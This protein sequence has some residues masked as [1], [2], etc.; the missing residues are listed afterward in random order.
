MDRQRKI[1][2]GKLAVNIALAFVAM[3]GTLLATVQE[4][5]A[6]PSWS[7]KY[8]ADCSACHYPVV[9]RLNSFGQQFRRAGYR[10]PDEIGKEQDVSKV[11]DFMSMRTRV[12]AGYDD[13][14]GK[15]ARTETTVSDATLFYAGSISKHF[16]AFAE[17]E[18]RSDGEVDLEIAQIQGV[19]GTADRYVSIRAGQGLPLQKV[20][21]GG[22]DRPAGISTNL[23]HS[24][25]VTRT[26]TGAGD[27]RGA[28]FALNREQKGI[29]VAYV[30]GPGRLAASIWNGMDTRGTGAGTRIDMDSQK[31]YL[32]FYEH[33][34]DDI[35][36]GF[37]L[38][39]YRGTHHLLAFGSPTSTT[40]PTGVDQRLDFT[41][42]GVNANKVFPAPFWS[43]FFE[44]QGGYI[45]SFDNVQAQIGPDVQGHA[46]YV[47][48]QQVFNGSGLPY[49]L[50]FI[51]RYSH[52][53][54]DSA[55]RNTTAKE[56]VAG[57][58]APLETWLRVAA[59]YRHT[60]NRATGLT[61]QLA[62]TEIQVN[63]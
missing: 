8:G 40:P 37:T 44:I 14:E 7:R 39:Y 35:A 23:L 9:P 58:V 49:G 41:R 46:F 16:S 34:L 6:L 21:F 52:L 18:F 11:G 47:E 15:V 51:E 62:L 38:F 12:R 61:N 55:R 43:G 36:S 45:R 10:M 29:E 22:F 30:Q 28:N 27:I 25:A 2:N 33:I 53:E 31:D 20:G 3:V 26:G 50:T 4:S 57:V 42:F 63:W 17:A 56:Y 60:D 48:L 32:V 54:Q 24:T 5:Q 59:E 13:R 19:F 1:L